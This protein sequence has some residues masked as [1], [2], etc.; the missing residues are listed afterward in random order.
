MGA[1]ENGATVSLQIPGACCASKGIL[2]IPLG[3]TRQIVTTQARGPTKRPFPSADSHPQSYSC[4][5]RPKRR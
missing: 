2:E 1:S 3:I 5:R 4:P